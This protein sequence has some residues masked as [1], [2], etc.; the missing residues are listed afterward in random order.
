[1]GPKGDTGAQGPAGPGTRIVYQ[2]AIPQ[3]SGLITVLVPQINF[4]N[5]PLVGIYVRFA[6]N[7]WTQVNYYWWNTSDGTVGGFEIAILEDGQVTIIS[8]DAVEYRIVLVI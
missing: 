2:G 4:T 7:E 8:L 3:P 1:M 5:P 6:S